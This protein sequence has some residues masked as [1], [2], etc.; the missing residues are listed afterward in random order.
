MKQASFEKSL[1]ELEEVVLKLEEGD[2]TLEESLKLFE[3]G[4]KLAGFCNEVLKNAE[5]KVIDLSKASI[6]KGEENA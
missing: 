6:E 5:Q 1:K 3:K 4:A 2:N